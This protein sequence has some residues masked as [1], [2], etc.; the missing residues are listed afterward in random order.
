MGPS[1]S[2]KLLFIAMHLMSEFWL[3]ALIFGLGATCKLQKKQGLV[4]MDSC[5]QD[6]L[7][8]GDPKQKLPHRFW[9]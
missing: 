1:Y 6:D 3:W 8:L 7:A 5:S 2:G 9:S 4:L